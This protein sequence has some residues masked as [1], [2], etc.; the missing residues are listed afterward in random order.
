MLINLHEKVCSDYCTLSFPFAFLLLLPPSWREEAQASPTA[1]TGAYSMK[2]R[3]WGTRQAAPMPLGTHPVP[4]STPLQPVP[5]LFQLPSFVLWC[6]GSQEGR[7]A[8][9][10]LVS[11]SWRLLCPLSHPLLLWLL[12]LSSLNME[13][14]KW[15]CHNC[16]LGR[17]GWGTLSPLLLGG[18]LGCVFPILSLQCSGLTCYLP[19]SLSFPSVCGF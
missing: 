12:L 5:P 10:L 8:L 17:A 3:G 11:R 7:T 15:S 9:L 16:V 18:L 4:H 6:L 13:P 14:R 2:S 1:A 19:S